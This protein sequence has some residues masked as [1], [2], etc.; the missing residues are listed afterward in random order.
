VVTKE[1][2]PSLRDQIWDAISPDRLVDVIVGFDSFYRDR[3]LVKIRS[4]L[5]VN[6]AVFKRLSALLGTEQ[7]EVTIE[8]GTEALSE[9][10]FEEWKN[11]EFTIRDIPTRLRYALHLELDPKP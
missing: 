3:L 1:T 6:Y 7:I 9:V 5:E 2:E 10:T 11:I 4:D 8:G